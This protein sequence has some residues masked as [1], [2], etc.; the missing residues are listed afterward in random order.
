MADEAT[1]ISVGCG[2]AGTSCKA[3]KAEKASVGD[4]RCQGEPTHYIWFIVLIDPYE[5]AGT[6]CRPHQDRRVDGERRR[7]LRAHEV[8]PG[9]SRT[10]GTLSILS[11]SEE[12]LRLS[13]TEVLRAAGGS[14]C[15]RAAARSASRTKSTCERS[16]RGTWNT[17]P[18]TVYLSCT[19]ASRAAAT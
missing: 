7:E 10:R 4:V 1:C 6:G 12:A 11:S 16:D 18:Q 8:A 3:S 17:W 15:R 5:A 13:S 19:R 9:R 14:S 2:T